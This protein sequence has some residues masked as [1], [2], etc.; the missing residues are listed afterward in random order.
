MGSTKQDVKSAGAL[1]SASRH[2]EEFKRDAV[3]LVTEE[4]YTFAAAAKAVGVSDQTLRLWRKKFG[5]APQACGEDATLDELR[6]ENKRLRSE[7]R[8]AELE[9]EI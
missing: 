6:A 2:S 5:P 8:R 1:S 9:R 3:R 4:G 7:L